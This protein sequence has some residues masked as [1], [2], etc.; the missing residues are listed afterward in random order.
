MKYDSLDLM[1]RLRMILCMFLL[2]LMGTA[3]PPD[4]F[5]AKFGGIGKE[6]GY[7]LREIYNRQYILVGSTSSY[8][9]GVTDV[10]IILIDSMGQEVW[11][12]VYGGPLADVGTCVLFNPVD[13]GFVFTGYSASYGNGGYDV[14]AMRTN[15][16]GEIIWQKYYGT[17]E[18]DF[19]NEAVI[20]GDGNIIICGTSFGG[21]Y[22]KSDGYIVKV[23]INSGEKIWEKHFGRNESDEFLRVKLRSPGSIIIGGNSNSYGDFNSDFWL[24]ELTNSGDSIISKNIGTSGKKEKL[25][26]FIIDKD[27]NI[28]IAGSFDTSA[29][30]SGKNV[31]YLYKISLGFNYVN[32]FK[33]GGGAGSNDHFRSI[34][35][36]A[37]GGYYFMSR[38]VLNGANGTDVQPYLVDNQFIFIGAKT[39]GDNY[40]DMGNQVIPTSDGGFAL[41]G[42]RS[43][44]ET[45]QPSLYFLKLDFQL[46]FAPLV[47]MSKELVLTTQKVY[48]YGRLLHVNFDQET[49]L[50]YTIYNSF[51]SIVHTGRL[52][53]GDDT[54]ILDSRFI[55]GFYVAV[56]GG[57]DP[58]KVR[59]LVSE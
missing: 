55:G 48:Y 28:V 41:V 11:N 3:Q 53:A 40:E 49:E 15:K 25:Y 37:S 9:A 33:F 26:D 32:S 12:K 23:D 42:Y 27:S 51:G 56:F 34:C 19:G 5:F 29:V 17:A 13:S 20:T 39:H 7:S 50:D 14:M 52:I 47:V 18:W 54:I 4:V 24:L 30:N 46:T 35:E 38:S 6:I 59:F 2:Y 1:R 43:E 16:R 21:P 10:Y 45:G 57:P 36:P 44:S 22:G 58:Q 31:A 8:G